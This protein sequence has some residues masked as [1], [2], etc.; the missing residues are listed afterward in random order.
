M[1]ARAIASIGLWRGRNSCRCKQANTY[2]TPDRRVTDTAQGGR[3]AGSG[4]LLPGPSV[5]PHRQMRTPRRN[6]NSHVLGWMA[7]RDTRRFFSRQVPLPRTG[8]LRAAL[9]LPF[10]LPAPAGREFAVGPG[11]CAG[12]GRG[13]LRVPFRRPGSDGS[14][15]EPG[16]GGSYHCIRRCRS[17]PCSG[18]PPFFVRSPA[19]SMLKTEP[20]PTRLPRR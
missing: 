11:F 2:G 7:R 13:L 3:T 16:C 1:A 6:G 12:P 4:P 17:M 5:G 20:I 18:R 9:L 19:R 10:Q 14:N 15:A 8:N